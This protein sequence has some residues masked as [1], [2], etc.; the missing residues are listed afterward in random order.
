[1][2]S[3]LAR[4]FS[5]LTSIVLAFAGDGRAESPPAQ[6]SQTVLQNEH[7]RLAFEPRHA[8]LASMRDAVTGVEHIR[9]LPASH[10]LW[11]ALFT[12][13]AGTTWLS[14][15]QYPYASAVVTRT[16]RGVQR[17]TFRWTQLPFGEK[18]ADGSVEVVIELPRESGIASWR[19]RV[20]NPSSTW[21]LCAV[22]FPRI[23]GFLEAGTYDLAGSF[24]HAETWGSLYRGYEGRLHMRYPDG[25]R[26]M[27]TQFACAS[28]GSNS[29]YM[30]AH[31]PRAWFKEFIIEPGNEYGI[32]TYAENMGVPG[33]DYL[34]PYAA[35]LG[36]Y[37]GDWL[38]G[39]KIYRQF[40]VTAPWTAKGRLSKGKATLRAGRN[41]GLWLREWGWTLN[42][43]G[44]H[45]T[46]INQVREAQD[47]FGVPLGFHWY[48]WPVA[49]FDTQYPHFL[50]A[51]AGVDKLARGMVDMGLVVM[52]YIN[53]RIV[54]QSHPDFPELAPYAAKRSPGRFFNERYGNGVK[55]APMCPATP[56]W[57]NTV[58]SNVE[59]VVT[60][61]GV[62]A[63]YIDQIAAA[64]PCLCKDETHGHPLGGGSWWVD[65]YRQMLKNVRSFARSRGRSV[66]IT[67]ECTAEPYMDGLDELLVV[68]E[69][70][71]FSIPVLPAVYSGYTIYFGS[72]EGALEQLSDEEWALEMGRDFVWG[73]QNGWFGFNLL[74]PEHE[75]KRAYLRTLAHA[76]VAGVKYLVEGELVGLL[77]DG[78]RSAYQD[79]ACVQGSVWKAEDGSLGIV[80]ANGRTRDSAVTISLDPR[81]FGLAPRFGGFW[82]ERIHPQATAPTRLPAGSTT[83]QETL[84][85]LEVRILSIRR[86]K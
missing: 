6:E 37:R 63:I 77:D 62:N 80:L 12:N 17:A 10:T 46:M 66:L 39:C 52:P 30:A 15:T 68:T 26:G 82:C 42:S 64:P 73:C 59:Q 20:D 19:I 53:G 49:D 29:V 75:Q 86:T 24:G 83:L 72:R 32:R 78:S 8:G 16:W 36:V 67:S 18:D 44:D 60:G 76:R 57:Q 38:T 85:P 4:A 54:D 35:M 69:R 41:I 79:V 61:L 43:V 48:N 31:D 70:S 1:M 7:V 2:R 9:E 25:W 51:K 56:F 3:T 14:S 27:S 40:A 55:Q 58:L 47:Y 81:A 21:G 65:G 71:K 28:Q 22:D 45:E 11:Q 84:G 5:V 33:S 50:P 23:N 13:D 74:L 34:A